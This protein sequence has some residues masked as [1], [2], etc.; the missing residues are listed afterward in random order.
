LKKISLFTVYLLVL[1][2]ISFQC[3][4]DKNKIIL[5]KRDSS[6]SFFFEKDST[7]NTQKSKET[8]I[9]YNYEPDTSVILGLIHKETFFGP[10]GYG[11]NPKK[12]S[13]EDCF[14]LNLYK[15]IRVKHIAGSDKDIDIEK[16]SI[17]KIQVYSSD[18]KI[19]KYMEN[20][21]GDRVMLKGILFGS[22]TG[23][24]HTPVIME[25]FEYKRYSP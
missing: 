25:V 4:T 24:H 13:K 17:Q 5:E 22:H 1:S 8:T 9:F 3:N 10:P 6:R 15:P 18:E 11:E 16:D 19:N 2:L 20:H 14:I 12:D 23:H 21:I 7:S